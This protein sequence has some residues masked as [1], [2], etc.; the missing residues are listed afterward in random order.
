MSQDNETEKTAGYRDAPEPVILELDML[1]DAGDRNAVA[2]RL[3]EITDE[4]L[5]D[6]L[7]RIR[8]DRR[9]IIWHALPEPRRDLIRK[10]LDPELSEFLD[11]TPELL[12]QKDILDEL[13][14]LLKEGESDRVHQMLASL[15]ND[16]IVNILDSMP[17][18]R[19]I[20]LWELV[21]EYQQGEV[22]SLLGD[23][24]RQTLL[25]K[26][27]QEEVVSATIDLH[28]DDLVDVVSS[29]PDVMADAI[30][31][32]LDVKD[33]ELIEARLEY[34]VD[35]AGR[36]MET[37]WIA[38]RADVSLGVVSRYL[39]RR[40]DLPPHTDGLMVVDRQG[41][42]LGKLLVSSILTLGD[43][44]VVG[45]VMIDN[46][47]WVS[48]N[49]SKD[50]IA[51]MFERREVSSVA[52]V[53]DEHRLVGRITLDE[54]LDLIREKAETPLM[55]MAGLKEDED[56]FAP[57]T[58]SALRRMLWLG[59]NLVTAFIAAWVIG[60]FE[61][62][63]QKI[64]ALAVLMPI[65]ASMGG[66]AGSQTLTLAIRGLALGQISSSN[67]RWLLV[68]EVA[69]AA[70]NGLIWA[71]VVGLVAYF[72]FGESGISIIIGI[73]MIINQFAAAL[74]G[75]AVPL[76]LDKYGIDPAL[77]GSVV[78]TTVT[79]V[80]GFMSFLGLATILLV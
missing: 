66:I 61:A 4:Y 58:S 68:K 33:R 77:S 38:V 20:T 79:D 24:V 2:M 6:W 14:T 78:L 19:R 5:A 21:P 16:D 51:D 80:V 76:I 45:D 63:L 64:V 75:I 37:E 70:I 23:N 25:K 69:I 56:L 9:V 34:G 30:L 1:A 15:S 62:T 12:A 31:Q 53:D 41:L 27:D 47:E 46:A 32:S 73:A 29:A 26:L 28:H 74:S 3:N 50:D 43:E 48:V 36:L 49:T 71:V 42:Y 7:P 13:N 40:G 55:H 60:L 72:W 44:L 39:K 8:E 35:S 59:I 10:K 17:V 22:L 54:A 65:V 18:T 52:V 57:I 67:T 11:K